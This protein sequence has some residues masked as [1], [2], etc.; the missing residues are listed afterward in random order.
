[1]L[2]HIKRHAPLL[3][4]GLVQ[5]DRLNRRLTAALRQGTPLVLVSAPAGFGK[6]TFITVWHNTRAG[7]AFPLAWLALDEHDNDPARFGAYW[8]AAME[9]VFPGLGQ[10]LPPE[11]GGGDLADPFGELAAA[12]GGQPASARP[13]MLV[14]DDYLQG[15]CSDWSSTVDVQRVSMADG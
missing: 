14:L 2:L 9:S 1:M 5:R 7:R 4:P 11:L 8:M 3:R 10:Q 6:I 15:A 12:L 13:A